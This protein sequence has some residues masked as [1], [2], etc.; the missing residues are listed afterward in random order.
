MGIIKK[1]LAKTNVGESRGSFVEFEL[2]E[3]DVIHIQ[4]KSWRVEMNKPEFI[5]YAKSCVEAG[6]ALKKLKGL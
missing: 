5:Q 6:E 4:N 2:N 1:I 3:G